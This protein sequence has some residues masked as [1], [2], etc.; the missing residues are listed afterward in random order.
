[1]TNKNQADD[2]FLGETR[3]VDPQR[4]IYVDPPFGWVAPLA[5]SS[6]AMGELGGGKS[7]AP[8]VDPRKGD[9]PSPF[10]EDGEGEA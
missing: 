7:A 3:D 9:K 10:A 8:V 4:K 5:G 6:W 2:A 1:M